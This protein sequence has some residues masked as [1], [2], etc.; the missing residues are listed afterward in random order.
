MA[1]DRLLVL[2]G[3]VMTGRGIDQI[4]PHRGDPHLEESYVVDARSY[5]R[6][7]ERV[8][9]AVPA[10][11]DPAWPWGDVL[12]TM[13]AAGPSWRVMNL[14]T[15]VTTS[16][17]FA[18]GKAVHYRMN[19]ANVACLEVAG[20]DVWTLANNHVLDHG[21]PGLLET[22]ETMRSHGLAHAGAGADSAEAWRPATVGS[23][24]GRLVVASVAHG[25]SGVPSPW[26]AAADRPG[27]ALLRD[28]SHQ[29]A[30][31]VAASL[32]R[33]SRPG[34]LCV[35]S[36]HWGSN[37]GY[38]VPSAQRRFAHRL[39]DAGVHVVHGHSSH[40]P[41]PVELYRGR[42]VLYGAG[43]LVNDYEGISGYE[44]FRDDLRL[45]YL[46]RLDAATGGLRA[47]RMV[48]FRSRRL[49]LERAAHSDVNW[50]ARTLDAASHA[51]DVRVR[52][53]ADGELALRPGA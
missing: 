12:E 13:D 49:R 50:L 28:L 45:L 44:E 14:E 42:L 16:Q 7:A 22:L 10:P 37:W 27:V 1:D 46:A 32:L 36:V 19:P 40:H 8:N 2:A 23:G 9:G 11:V 41:R 4:L 48:P 34:D 51:F 17:E 52:A 30:D 5:V 38:D 21:V 53:T 25:S 3:D 31:E 29:Q 26:T 20:V 18:P 39:V 43:D 6:L 47:L 33:D 15:G 24:P 35:V